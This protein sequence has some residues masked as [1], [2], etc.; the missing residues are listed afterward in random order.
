MVE[1][2]STIQAQVL[3]VEAYG[4]FLKHGDETVFVVL[5]EVSWLDTKA[6]RDRVHVGEVFDVYVLRYN[7]RDR[8]IV[9]S[10]RRAHDELN[11]Y[12]ALSR[13]PPAQILCGKVVQTSDD[14]VTV[15]LANG[16]SGKIPKSRVP[17]DLELGE[18][19]EVV[20]VALEVDEGDLIL[21]FVRREMDPSAPAADTIP[22]STGT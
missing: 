10:I 16:A 20:I 17:A 19:V 6:L 13:L 22:A 5:P 15:R 14:R 8:Q 3:R 2:G 18:A 12:R 1:I 4:V 9:G 7:Y 11:P 21:D